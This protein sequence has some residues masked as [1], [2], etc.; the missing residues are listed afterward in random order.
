MIRSCGSGLQDNNDNNATMLSLHQFYQLPVFRRKSVIS[1]FFHVVFQ[2]KHIYIYMRKIQIC[3]RKY[4]NIIFFENENRVKSLWREWVMENTEFN[5][6]SEC[7]SSQSG[8]FL[9]NSR[10]LRNNVSLL[11]PILTCWASTKQRASFAM[12]EKVWHAR[13]KTEYLHQY[14]E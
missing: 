1:K 9:G 14:V 2:Q 6:H 7:G 11:M 5:I 4:R 8:L 13:I 12:M 3:L 10:V